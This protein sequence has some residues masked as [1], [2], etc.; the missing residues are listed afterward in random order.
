[1]V[2]KGVKRNG[3]LSKMS[4]VYRANLRIG[5]LSFRPT[6]V[7]NMGLA[8]LVLALLGFGWAVRPVSAHVPQQ[9]G[10]NLLANPSFEEPFLPDIRPDGGGFVAHGWS[11]WWYNDDGPVY[12]GP[13][14]KQATVAIDANRVRSG[15]NAQ[16]YFRDYAKHIA[17]MYQQVKVPANSMLR[18]T[19]Y[20]H[21]WSGFCKKVDGVKTCDPSNSYY[22]DGA[23]PPHMRIGIDPTGGVDPFSDK[24]VWSDV[25]EVYDHFELF[26]VEAKAKG[27]TIT[28]FTYSAPEWAAAVINIY[29]DDAALV[30]IDGSTSP[31]VA[32]PAASPASTTSAPSAPTQ[33]SQPVAVVTETPQPDGSIWHTVQPGQTLSTIARAYGVDVPTIAQLNN[34]SGDIIYAGQRLL[35]KAVPLPAETPTPTPEPTT[36]TPPPATEATAETPPAAAER[37]ERGQICLALFDDLDGDGIWGDAEPMLAG[38]VV[39]I[40]GIITDSYATDGITERYCF[41]DLEAGDYIAAVEPPEGYVLTGLGQVPITL[42]GSGGV[43]LNFGASISETADVGDQGT[44]AE[45]GGIGNLV[46]IVAVVGVAILALGGGIFAYLKIYKQRGEA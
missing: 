27:D 34:I 24:I 28:V 16:Q 29:W 33:V 1:M 39:S 14:F 13:E 31:T 17:G 11:A 2:S 6:L 40:S 22:G 18:F 26:T 12:D 15:G 42:S 10:T 30:T 41:S 44:D 21:A 25:K 35:I 37:P 8:V 7:L 23:N 4:A 5:G 19:I 3:T 43:S 20:G 46:T 36:E 9:S 32:P 38:G 45:G